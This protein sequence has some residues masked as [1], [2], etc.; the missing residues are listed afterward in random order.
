LP[1]V[2]SWAKETSPA[3][4]TVLRPAF[5]RRARIYDHEIRSRSGEADDGFTGNSR[6]TGANR[7]PLIGLDA[8]GGGPG[9]VK[10]MVGVNESADAATSLCVRDRAQRKRCFSRIRFA[11]DMNN[12]A[13][14]PTG[15][16]QFGS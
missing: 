15:Y 3:H 4:G 5:K 16:F 8:V 1:S 10:R 11:V 12:P 9:E 13:A 2:R 6:I 7:Q 14:R